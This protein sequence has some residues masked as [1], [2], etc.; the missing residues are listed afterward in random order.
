MSHIP[1]IVLKI[2]VPPEQSTLR[3]FYTNRILSHNEN[4]YT[5]CPDSG[6][7]LGLPFDFQITK[8]CSNKVPLGIH[9]SMYMFY[10]R[11]ADSA[12]TLR[13]ESRGMDCLNNIVEVPQAYY[14]YP[15]SSIVKTPIR[16]SNSVGI[17]DSGYRGEITAFVDKVDNQVGTFVIHAMDRYFQICHPSLMP[18]KVIMVNTKEELGLTERGDRGF[19]STGR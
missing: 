4:L 9:C 12:S 14:L 15:R 1:E 18:F 17:I 6:F 3:A 13:A 8:T 19:G 11:H 16:L 2:Y 7:D 10:N 5:L